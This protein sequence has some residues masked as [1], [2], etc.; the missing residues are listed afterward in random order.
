MA[1]SPGTRGQTPAFDIGERTSRGAIVDRATRQKA[2]RSERDSANSRRA[3]PHRA[4]AASAPATSAAASASSTARTPTSPQNLAQH[5]RPEPPESWCAEVFDLIEWRRFEHLVEAL[6]AQAGFETRSQPCGADGGVDIWLHSKNRGGAAVSIVQCKHWTVWK[7][8]VKAIRELRGV[9]AA[10]GIARGQFV[11]TS[12]YTAEAREFARDN[13][14]ALHDTR[15][16][17]ALI[18][19][20][21]AEQQRALLRVSFY[22]EYWR[23]TCASCGI[24]LVE[25]AA[26]DGGK[27]FW[28]CRHYPKCKTTMRRS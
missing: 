26:R 17:L 25:R 9:M 24:K 28:G 7:I 11:T 21:D 15:S 22:G 3:R 8:G 20:R 5:S 10:H 27:P 2:P 4:S 13:G 23:P 12:G 6:F 14:I 18:A 19:S 16:L 1:S